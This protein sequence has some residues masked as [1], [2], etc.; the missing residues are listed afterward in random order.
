[1]STVLSLNNKPDSHPVEINRVLEFQKVVTKLL[2]ACRPETKHKEFLS[3][4]LTSV[5]QLAEGLGGSLWVK[6]GESL[7]PVFHIGQSKD[8]APVDEQN[9]I[10]E[11]ELLQKV[12]RSMTPS[13]FQL[14]LPDDDSKDKELIGIYLPIAVNGDLFAI[15]KIVKKSAGNVIYREE[16]ELL[17]SLGGL[18]Q[19]YLSQMHMPKVLGRLEDMGRLLE[20]NNEIFASGNEDEIAYSIANLAPSV[21]NC[22]RCI[23]AL[24]RKKKLSI[25]AITGQDDIE[26]KSALVRNLQEIFTT[27]AENRESMTITPDIAA[28]TDDEKFVKDVANYFAVNPFKVIHAIPVFDN[29]NLMAVIS[30]EASKEAGFVP[31]DLAIFKFIVNQAGLVLKNMRFYSQMPFSGLW[32]KMHALKTRLSGMP[33]FKLVTRPLLLFLALAALFLVQVDN[34]ISGNCEVFPVER[35]YARAR[36]DGIL[37]EFLVQEG[38]RVKINSVVALLNDTKIKKKLREAGA[39]REILKA[40]I[41]K[42]FGQGLVADYEIERLKLKDIELEID[43]LESELEDT[44]VIAEGGGTVITSSSRFTERIGKPVARGEELIEIGS[45]ENM[46]LEVA[47]SEADIKFIRPGQ[48]VQFLLNFLPERRLSANVEA[49]RQKSE[50]REDGNFFIVEARLDFPLKSL[51]QGMKGK[52]KIYGDKASIFKVYMR[53]MVDFFRI[54]VFF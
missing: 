32:K 29:E 14:Y 50:L 37:K 13:L 9:R 19:I 38:S 54:K 4:Y 45:M 48:S 2:S 52:A 20:V 17:H 11:N 1:M 5:I 10:D 43:L 53:D 28:K 39:R 26:Q 30:I 23:V 25:R 33:R 3:T 47:V 51:R 35:Y 44:R 21:I 24:V 12:A 36:I 31:N 27:V 15:S 16:I 34:K 18:L 40:N 49:I 46:L 8:L 41:I 42:L 22:D 7:E 6:Q